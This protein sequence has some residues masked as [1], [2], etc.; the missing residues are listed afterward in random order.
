VIGADG[1][2]V[3]LLHCPRM[4]CWH[5]RAST[6]RRGFSAEAEPTELIWEWRCRGLVDMVGCAVGGDGSGVM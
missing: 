6:R 2:V 3:H 4:L 5:V 1:A